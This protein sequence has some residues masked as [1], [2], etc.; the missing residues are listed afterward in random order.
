MTNQQVKKP[1][2]GNNGFTPSMKRQLLR[3]YQAFLDLYADRLPDVAKLAIEVGSKF[4]SGKATLQELTSARDACEEWLLAHGEASEQGVS[5]F[6]TKAVKFVASTV[7]DKSF[8]VVYLEGLMTSLVSYV[9]A[10]LDKNGLDEGTRRVL[11]FNFM[12]LELYEDYLP[13][14]AKASIEVG[15]RYGQGEAT[16]VELI[17][18]REACKSWQFNREYDATYFAALAANFA[19]HQCNSIT[20]DFTLHLEMDYFLLFLGR[21]ADHSADLERCIRAAFESP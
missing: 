15:R 3:F 5:E 16:L 17:T 10:F 13:D 19:S 4:Q 6:E 11:K 2:F 18:A 7:K 21:A 9:Q 14:V 8:L 12:Y 20:D 1:D